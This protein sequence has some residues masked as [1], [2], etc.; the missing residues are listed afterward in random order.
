MTKSA[1]NAL[2]KLLRN[3]NHYCPHKMFPANIRRVQDFQIFQ[4]RPLRAP[5]A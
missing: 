4:L 5:C 1:V 2:Y 3:L